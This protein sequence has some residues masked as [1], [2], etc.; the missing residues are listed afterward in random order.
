MSDRPAYVMSLELAKAIHSHPDFRSSYFDPS[1][2]LVVTTRSGISKENLIEQI[3][4]KSEEKDE[5]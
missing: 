4:S 2:T 1:G 5:S 3:Q